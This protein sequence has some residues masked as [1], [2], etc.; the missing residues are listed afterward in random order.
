MELVEKICYT[1]FSL[2]V[3]S[4]FIMVSVGII[5]AFLKAMG[6]V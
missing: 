1:I 4:I 6:P 3:A 5:W 2:C